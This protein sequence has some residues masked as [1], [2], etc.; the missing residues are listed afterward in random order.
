MNLI[1]ELERAEQAAGKYSLSGGPLSYCHQELE[2]YTKRLHRLLGHGDYFIRHKEW[3]YDPMTLVVRHMPSN[4][5]LDLERARNASQLL[6]WILQIA[7]QRDMPLDP[8]I[9]LLEVVA[10]VR[11]LGALQGNFCPDGKRVRAIKW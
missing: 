7:K 3:V 11:G 6:D 1:I 4:Y 9:R 10:D 2:Q 5:E 8:L